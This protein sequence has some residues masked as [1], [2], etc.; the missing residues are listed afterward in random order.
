L[1]IRRWFAPER[2][3]CWS[4]RFHRLEGR[5]YTARRRRLKLV[6][7]ASCTEFLEF[8]SRKAGPPSRMRGVC[9]RLALLPVQLR[10]YFHRS[11]FLEKKVQKIA[12]AS[13]T[14]AKRQGR[15]EAHPPAINDKGEAR[16]SI[17]S[18]QPR[19]SPALFPSTRPRRTG[20]SSS[21]SGESCGA[22]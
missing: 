22:R 1:H 6:N 16:C 15:L 8:F 11:E 5:D 3:G 21:G 14:Q 20:S 7:P 2:P 17:R 12:L 18:L 10:P 4:V 13:L 19:L 9:P